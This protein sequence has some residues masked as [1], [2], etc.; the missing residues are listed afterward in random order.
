MGKAFSALKIILIKLA[1]LSII[2]GMIGCGTGGLSDAPSTGTTPGTTPGTTSPVPTS[3]DLL[4]SSPQLNSDDAAKVTLTALVRD[5]GNRA[6]SGQTV[7]FSTSGNSTGSIVV[8]QGTTDASGTATATLGTGGNPANR[9]IDLTATSGSIS[10]VNTVNV[11]GTTISVNGLNSL[12][13]GASTNL[14]IFLSNSA[15]TG[16]VGKTVT[17]TSQKGNT[18]SASSYITNANGQV[19]V[20]VTA[21]VSGDDVITAS[22]IGATKTFALNVNP[23]VLAMTSPS[24]SA[25][26]PIGVNQP[27]TVQLTNAGAPVSG[28]TINFMTTRGALSGATAV[29][30][31]TGTATVNV[32]STT[33]GPALLSAFVPG[34]AS[35]QTAVE[36]VATTPAKMKLQA[37]P[38]LIGTNSGTATTEKSL[39]TAVVRDVNDNLVKN[40]TVNFSL[41]TDA[42]GGTLSPVSATTDSSGTATTYYIAGPSSTGTDGV[43]ISAAVAGSPTVTATTQLTVSQKAVFV[44]LGTGPK[45]S[46]LSDGLR[47]QQDYVALVTNATGKPISGATVSAVLT[48]QYY[49]K[50]FYIV[51]GTSWLR[52]PTLVAA[53]STRPDVPA[54]ANEDGITHNPL[55]DFNGQLDPGEDQNNNKKLD[56]GNIASVVATTTDSN[57]FST[58]SIIY[59]KDYAYWVNVRLAV[60]ASTEGDTTSAVV[61]FDLPGAAADFSDV[62]AAPPGFVSPFGVS[63]S[64][65]DTKPDAPTGITATAVS[66]T[67]IN[68]SWTASAGASGYK[69]YRDGA[70]VRTTANVSVADTGLAA[71]KPY[72]YKLSAFD[73]TG[74]E[75]GQS[76]EVCV[77]TP[78]LAPPTNPTVAAL[79][80]SQIMFSWTAS[81]GASG[82]KIYRDGTLLRS[83]TAPTVSV[84]DVGLTT[85]T[86]YCYKVSAYDAT[87]IESAQTVQL[88]ATTPMLSALTNLT[89]TAAS[90]SQIDLSWT[91]ATGASSYR[92]YRGV[93]GAPVTPLKYVS[94]TSTSDTGLAANTYICYAVSVLDGANNESTLS[95]QLC[96]TTYGPPPAVPTGLTVRATLPTQIDL[97][98]TASAGASQ[99]K[100]YRNGVLLAATTGTVYSDT[101]VAAN[102]QYAYTI[103]AIDTTGSESSPSGQTDQTVVNTGLTV[104]SGVTVTVNSATQITLSWA[105]SGGGLVN[106]YKIYKNGTLLGAVTSLSIV[107]GGLTANTQYCYSITATSASGGESSRS[108]TVCGTTQPPP[109]PASIDLLVSSP[110]LNSDGLSTVTLTAVVKDT[111]NRSLSGQA[112]SFTADSGLLTVTSGTTGAN[113]TATASLGTGGDQTNRI[114]N[115]TASTAGINAVNTVTVTGTTLSISGASSLSFGDSTPLTIFLKD[116]AGTGIAGK[117]V[118]ITSASGNTLSAGPYKT[119]TAGQVTVTVTAAVGGADKIRAAA[120]GATKEFDLTVNANI[121]KFTSPAPPPASLTEIAIGAVPL[122]AISAKYTIG[123]NPAVGVAVSFVTTRGTLS[124]ASALTDASGIATV[125][126]A[127]T[128][129]GPVLFLATVAGG[130]SAQVAAE[131]VATTVNSVTLQ[132]APNTIGTNSSGA[133][134]TEKSLITA[135]VRDANNNL[136]KN[137][138]VNFNIVTD[139]SGGSLSP[140]SAIT[141][142]SGTA[143]TY[144][145]AGGAPSPLNGVKIQGS[146]AGTSVTATT[147]LT[148]A[149]KALFITLATGPAVTAMTDGIRYQKDYVALVTDA[150]GDP[151]AGATV[152]ATVTPVYYK[153]GYYIWSAAAGRWV[154]VPTLQAASTTLPGIPAC[155]NED[156]LLHNSLY[157]FNGVLDTDPL[158]GAKEDQNGNNR[159]DPGNVASVTATVTDAAGHSTLSIVYAKDYAYWVNVKLEAFASSGG[160]TASAV[161]TFDLPGV[162][163]DYTQSNIDPPGNP[164][165]FGTLTSCFV[166][167]TVTPVSST[168]MAITWQK[169]ADAAS[170]NV[171]RGGVFLKNVTTNTTTDDT[172]AAATQYCYQIRTVNAL[173]LETSFTGTTCATTSA[174]ALPAPTGLT[175]TALSPSQIRVSWDNMGLASYNIYRDAALVPLRSVVSTSITDTNLLANTNYCY[176]VSGL[177]VAGVESAK[178]GALCATTQMAAPAT[179]T[180]LTATGGILAAGPPATY[181]VTLNWNA[182]AGAALYNIYRIGIVASVLSSTGVTATDTTVVGGTGYCYTISAVDVLGNESA[183]STPYCTAT[184]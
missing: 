147:T 124:A 137:K 136:V 58:V 93:G 42:S 122:Q 41:T 16:I 39:I 142:G 158:S 19:A 130:P 18:L 13:L 165:P 109:V 110:Q 179:P 73:S 159:L 24:A 153:R 163:G 52:L 156:G 75:S 56:P 74:S 9:A 103:T 184:P 43:K 23:F 88:C 25:E 65:F 141:D 44:T 45:I 92:I 35:V 118:T 81:A 61:D 32:S 176:A 174:A 85:N 131:F 17:L 54:C 21:A 86:Q 121:L 36:F 30:T 170:Y 97:S 148:V 50:G 57:G 94:Q 133:L 95:S 76:A 4:V 111:G 120:I 79:S 126:A 138:T 51:S 14:T 146:V 46:T 180:G 162:G 71:G 149:K 6:L 20:A 37:D 5:N 143:S 119:D 10:A 12:S 82:Y 90:S 69:I 70:V 33:T 84:T 105:N 117:T 53:S 80:S 106:G 60:R 3:I 177:S 107:D 72:C 31:G 38:V 129:S 140:P 127:A 182:S 78:T 47:Y 59:A 49:K 100:I 68:L 164:S 112:V 115:L 168:K 29:T 157:D 62:K 125:F 135:V 26:L 67:Q 145:I 34:G 151:V 172:V 155:A 166:D 22:A 96:T 113:G 167:L 48:P 2:S 128:N 55:Y 8:A 139:A 63:T 173:G 40:R 99:Y 28:T 144:F 11:I 134:T 1:V 91:A 123:G 108:G 116:S 152:V 161:V 66:T 87:G 98:W 160:S 77:T 183:Q 178:S 102:T 89:V 150:A 104:P 132:A 114:I 101:A 64:C 15:G 83:V 169:S 7:A 171:Y 154:Q 181:K 175:V 27:V